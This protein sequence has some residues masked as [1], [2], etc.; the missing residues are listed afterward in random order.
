[1]RDY[2]VAGQLGLEPTPEEYVA[3]MVAVFREVWRV[4][5]PDGTVWLNLGDSYT[6]GGRDGHGTRVGYKQQTNR[7]MNGTCDPVRA[8]QPDGLK[9]KDLIGIPWRVA[10]ALQADG[11]WLRSD[12]VWAK[13]NPMPES[14][15]DRPTKAHEYLFLLAKSARYFYDAEAIKEEASDTSGW[16][17]QRATGVDTWQYSVRAANADLGIR[18]GIS[19]GFGERGARNRRTVWTVATQPC[20]LAHFATMPPALV[21]PCIKAGTSERGCCPTCGA[22]WQRVVEKERKPRGDAFGRKAVVVPAHGQAGAPY[23]ETVAAHT[24]G[25]QPTCGCGMPKDVQP[26]DWEIIASPTGERVADDPS[27]FTGRAGYNRP[28]GQDEGQRPITR[29]EQRRYAE[30]LR[31]SPDKP[32]LWQ[33]AGTALEHYMRTDRAGARPVPPALLDDWIARGILQRVVLPDGKPPEPVPCVVLDPFG[34]A[35]TTMLVADRLGRHGVGVEL[36][37]EYT[38]MARRRCYE[39]APLLAWAGGAAE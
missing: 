2:G 7:G 38:R 35:G 20:P 17:K 31:A 19:S 37:G 33:E 13:P 10:F 9:P 12:I 24:L 36:S 28:R 23:M 5:R 25:W 16:A 4:L 27:L 32:L 1:L 22:P 14:V 26:D 30:Q 18:N 11:W 29:Y 6:S 34:G 8:P 15:T 3:N 21:E 39:D